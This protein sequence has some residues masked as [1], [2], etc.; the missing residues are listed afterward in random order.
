M[1]DPLVYDE[2]HSYALPGINGGTHRRAGD[3]DLV[4]D[5]LVPFSRGLIHQ[6]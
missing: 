6:C 3:C 2:S 4:S 5:R 1:R